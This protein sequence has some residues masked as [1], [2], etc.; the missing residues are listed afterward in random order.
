[1]SLN[2]PSV[3]VEF[4]RFE[5][6]TAAA[7]KRADTA[8]RKAA[9][10]TE[11]I[12]KSLAPVLTGHLKTSIATRIVGQCAADVIV[13]AAY[14]GFVEYGTSLMSAQ[15]F[16]HPAFHQV[17]PKYLAALAQIYKAG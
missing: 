12:A 5:E 15:P 7:I 14:A 1:M 3:H 4:N 9:A 8:T 16:M 11:R 17:S 2:G 6:L 13:G 10:D